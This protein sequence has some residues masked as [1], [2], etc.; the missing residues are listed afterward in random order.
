M[1]K[2]FRAKWCVICYYHILVNWHQK[3]SSIGM[4]FPLEV[5]R[6]HSEE[7]YLPQVLEN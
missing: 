4:L 6:R 2:V 1:E 3:V 7:T 5:F